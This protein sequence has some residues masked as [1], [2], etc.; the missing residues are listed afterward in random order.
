M[1][2]VIRVIQHPHVLGECLQAEFEHD[3]AAGT[4]HDVFSIS[5]DALIAALP[6]ATV[7][8]VS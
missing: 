7:T 6:G 3:R 5:T 1:I 8:D 4:H 2:R